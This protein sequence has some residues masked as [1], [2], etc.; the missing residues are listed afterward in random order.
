MALAVREIIDEEIAMGLVYTKVYYLQL[1]KNA[2]MS[3]LM[4]LNIR[5][6]LIF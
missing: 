3:R 2:T 1:K 5:N 6:Q 4:T